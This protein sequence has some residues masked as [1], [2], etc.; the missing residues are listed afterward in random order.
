VG[1][2]AGGDGKVD[3]SAGKDRIG[4]VGDAIGSHAGGCME[5]V[6]LLL[7][8]KRVAPLPGGEQVDAATIGR[9]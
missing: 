5:I 9:P 2:D 6:L 1:I 8:G 7:D 4:K 3:A